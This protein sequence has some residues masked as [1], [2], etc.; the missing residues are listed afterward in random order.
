MPRWKSSLLFVL[1][2]ALSLAQ[3][4][5]PLSNPRVRQI[6]L[7]MKCYCGCPYT[8]TD[9]D[10]TNCHYATPARQKIATMVNAGRTDQEIWN[11][12]VKEHG[13]EALLTPP[14][15]GFFAVGWIMPFAAIAMG[16]GVIWWLI[17]KFRRPLAKPA[18][19]V[20]PEALDAYRA[21]IEKD[22]AKLE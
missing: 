19:D 10:M 12:F 22:L 14:T 5:N 7:N 16:L 9:C 18:G 4:G 11:E 21:Q 20:A 2:A 6:G 1:L 17:Q 15:E 3:T 8:V 13:R